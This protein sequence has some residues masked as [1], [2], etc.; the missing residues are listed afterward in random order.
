MTGMIL[1]ISKDSSQM[2]KDKRKGDIE[3]ININN[4]IH[5]N[6]VEMNQNSTTE[7]EVK[8]LDRG[9]IQQGQKIVECWSL[10]RQMG[11]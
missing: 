3:I 6:M 7:G 10:K 11:L 4:I 9:V 5:T 1:S 8:T 2:D